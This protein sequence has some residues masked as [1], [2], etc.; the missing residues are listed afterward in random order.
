LGP[1]VAQTNSGNYGPADNFPGIGS[2]VGGILPGIVLATTTFPFPAPGT[3]TAPNG[4][5]QGQLTVPAT[6]T[7]A[8]SY[9][10]DAPFINR[11]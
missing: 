6:F 11:L 8:P 3:P 7:I 2:V 5:V 10:P 1:P 9:L 4:A